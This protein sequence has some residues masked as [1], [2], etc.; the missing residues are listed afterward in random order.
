[1]NCEILITATLV[2]TADLPKNILK[3]P[4]NKALVL[5]EVILHC[6]VWGWACAVSFVFKGRKIADLSSQVIPKSGSSSGINI[7][8][9][10]DHDTV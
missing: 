6:S 8:E 7:S 9:C 2:I 10:L 5:K 3:F 4:E 1:M